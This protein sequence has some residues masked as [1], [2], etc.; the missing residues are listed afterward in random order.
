[1]ARVAVAL[2][3]DWGTAAEWATP[4]VAWEAT[5]LSWSAAQAVAMG[6]LAA[7]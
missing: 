4:V 7:D 2:A 3:V 6:A 1:V 5:V